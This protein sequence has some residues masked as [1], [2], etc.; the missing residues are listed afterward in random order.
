MGQEMGDP[1]HPRVPGNLDIT[2]FPKYYADTVYEAWAAIRFVST[3]SQGTELCKFDVTSF[4]AM[5]ARFVD[6]F[7][8]GAHPCRIRRR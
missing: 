4:T 1:S 8:A 3:L 5:P 7:P 6:D 2:L